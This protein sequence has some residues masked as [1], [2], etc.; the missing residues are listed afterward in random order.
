MCGRASSLIQWKDVF[1]YA[2]ALR[3]P[4]DLPDDPEPSINV[5]PSRWRRKSEPE[6]I[7]WETLPCIRADGDIDRPFEAIWPYLP[8]W[9][10]RQ[11]PTLKNGKTLSTANARLRESGAPFAPTFMPAWKHGRRVV[12]PV[13]WFYEFDGRTHPKVPYAV[14]PLNAPCWLMA[15]L[16]G[17]ADPATT[18]HEHSTTVITVSP[19]EVLQSVGHHRSP[20]LLRDGEEASTWLH[21][22]NEEALALLRPFPNDEMGTEAID[23]GIKI[24]GN[25]NVRL[26][27]ILSRVAI[28]E[29]AG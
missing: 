20:A 14:Y 18:G 1:E 27:G 24:P 15:G 10:Q 22:S 23:M 8:P 9:S 7:D 21:G 11:L 12:I 29:T 2:S 3:P 19:N 6:S 5:S 16:L 17:D 26:P 4:A 25:Q 28:R 13:S